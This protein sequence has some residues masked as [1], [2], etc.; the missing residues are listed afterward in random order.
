MTIHELHSILVAASSP[1]DAER[2]PAE[3]RM[4]EIELY[5]DYWGTLQQIYFEASISIKVRTLAIICLKNG[6]SRYWRRSAKGAIPMEQK[7]IIKYLN[8]NLKDITF[9]QISRKPINNSHLNKL[10]SLL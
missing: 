10:W 8:S 7:Q 3:Q 5:P 6:V 9:Y 1:I 4:V 2:K